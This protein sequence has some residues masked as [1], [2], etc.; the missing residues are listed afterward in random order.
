M[1]L[2]IEGAVAADFGGGASSATIPVTSGGTDRIVV[3]HICTER[4]ATPRRTVT[5]VTAAGLTFAKRK[6][7]DVGDIYGTSVEVWWAYAAAQQTALTIT[8]TMSGVINSGTHAIFGVSGCTNFTDPWTANSSVPKTAVDTGAGSVVQV[9]GVSTTEPN[10]IV[11]G[12]YGGETGSTPNAETT[13][14]AFTQAYARQN[15]GGSRHSSIWA[16]Y[17]IFS[18]AQAGITVGSASSTLSN[19]GMI[20]DAITD[21]TPP[22]TGTWAS[23]EAPD[24]FAAAGSPIEVVTW[25]STEAKDVF[26]AIG[27]ASSVTGV[28]ASLETKDTFAGAGLPNPAGHWTSTE[29]KDVFAAAGYQQIGGSWVSTEAHD[30]FSAYGGQPVSGTWASTEAKDGFAGAATTHGESGVWAST[31]PVD[32]VNMI[33]YI[34]TTGSWDSTEAEDR[35]YA[36]A[37]TIGAAPKGRRIFLSC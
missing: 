28:W 29:A 27:Y 9:T 19:W 5:S 33:G 30:V 31:E 34:P 4:N 32:V 17:Y 3:V 1:T 10:C 7:L 37:Y 13:P 22:L 14:I 21:A 2:A 26:A 15:W 20:A 6:D 23:T 11:F 8:V 16:E 18:S 12:F 36:L 24:T 35:F 25:A